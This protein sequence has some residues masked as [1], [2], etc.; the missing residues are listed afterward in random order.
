ME[1]NCI[2][3]KETN[4]PLQFETSRFNFE[5]PVDISHENFEKILS[6]SQKAHIKLK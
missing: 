6:N 4:T 3:D 2:S 5:N 1:N